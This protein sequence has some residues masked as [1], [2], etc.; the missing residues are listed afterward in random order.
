[1]EQTSGE[2]E[3]SRGVIP[4]VEALCLLK[5]LWESLARQHS[6]TTKAS[7]VFLYSGDFHHLQREDSLSE[8][9]KSMKGFFPPP[10]N[11]HY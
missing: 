10:T 7:Q 9:P 1:M 2:T 4:Q 5:Q 6:F 3:I 8:E 11:K